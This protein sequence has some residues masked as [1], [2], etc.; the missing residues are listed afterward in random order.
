MAT[1]GERN[2]GGGAYSTPGV[3]TPASKGPLFE[4]ATVTPFLPLKV[5]DVDPPAVEYVTEQ[6]VLT[7]LVWNSLAGLTITVTYRILRAVDGQIDIGQTQFQPVATRTLQ[8]FTLTFPQGFLL[9]VQV[10]HPNVGPRRGQTFCVLALQ[11]NVGTATAFGTA[12][13]F[14]DYLTENNPLG[15]P[16]A[17]QSSAIDGP[18]F[19]RNII[20]ANPAAGADIINTVP[21]NAR[22]RPIAFQYA[23][24]TS[25][26]VA[27]RV[28][29]IV[30]TDGAAAFFQNNQPPAQA[31]S[32]TV[33]Y[34]WSTLTNQTA[35]VLGQVLTPFPAGVLL[36]PG[37]Q[38]NT[39]TN[40]IQAGD[41]Y[42]GIRLC[43]EEWIET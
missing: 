32:T 26:A 40:A 18:G 34:N 19:I 22:W 7:L 29:A 28:S 41:Q 1:E 39:V 10:G 2:R 17:K 16:G 38:I 31:A 20:P 24:V 30:L 36:E 3:D 42:S 6:D 15:W 27:N 37:W 13:L 23:L 25:A 12:T 33:V 35:V 4:T 14:A 9:N 43:V 5:R 8:T 21:P 11:R